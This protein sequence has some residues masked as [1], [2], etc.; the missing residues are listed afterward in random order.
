MREPARRPQR[1]PLRPAPDV[2]RIPRA[3]QSMLAAQTPSDA[4]SMKTPLTNSTAKASGSEA[5]SAYLDSSDEDAAHAQDAR[6][7]VSFDGFDTLGCGANDA[8][9]TSPRP[10]HSLSATPAA[11]GP[12][13][14]CAL[15][16]AGTQP[17]ARSWP[18]APCA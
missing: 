7:P 9:L 3:P 18:L 5:S 15:L 4:P 11:L 13:T 8:S 1:R 12:V 14:A 2:T 10:A 6:T 16:P 17:R